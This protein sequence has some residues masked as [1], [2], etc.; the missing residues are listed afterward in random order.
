MKL[1]EIKMK[2]IKGLY[3]DDI[4]P[5]CDYFLGNILSPTSPDYSIKPTEIKYIIGKPTSKDHWAEVRRR[6]IMEGETFDIII[7][8]PDH[9]WEMVPTRELKDC[10]V[11]GKGGYI[12]KPKADTV[13]VPLYKDG[14]CCGC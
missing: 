11:A 13:L 14:V 5:D 6:N 4:D 3:F 10:S 8:E 2:G 12:I 7:Y 9:N 1:A